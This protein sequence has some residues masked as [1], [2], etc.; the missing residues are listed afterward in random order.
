MTFFTWCQLR[1]A[2]TRGRR[3]NSYG[4]PA[5]ER[6]IALTE[7]AVITRPVAPDWFKEGE[8]PAMTAHNAKALQ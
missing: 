4:L 5:K 1:E 8:W 3:N 6:D 2:V 7:Q